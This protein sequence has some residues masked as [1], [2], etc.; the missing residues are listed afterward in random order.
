ML[1]EVFFAFVFEGELFL[2]EKNKK[3]GKGGGD[4]IC[5]NILNADYFYQKNKDSVIQEGVR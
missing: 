1:S 5:D 2:A 4:Y 3:I